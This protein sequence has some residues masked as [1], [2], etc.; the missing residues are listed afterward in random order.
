[1]KDVAILVTESKGRE[2]DSDNSPGRLKEGVYNATWPFKAG[3]Q[4]YLILKKLQ[5]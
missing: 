3:L 1:M 4:M 5:Y 2:W